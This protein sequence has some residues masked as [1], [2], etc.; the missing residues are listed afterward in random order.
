MCIRDSIKPERFLALGFFI[1]IVAG[2]FVLTLPVSSAD[3]QTVGIRQAMFTATSAVCVTGLTIVDAVSYTHLDVYKRQQHRQQ[4]QQHPGQHPQHHPQKPLP[5]Q[6]RHAR[7]ARGR[8]LGQMC[9]RD[10]Y[11]TEAVAFME[12]KVGGG[13]IF[14]AVVHM[15]EKTP[16]L[17]LCFTPVSYTHLRNFVKEA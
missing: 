7:R 9:I 13:N 14:S 17:H 11:F 8:G 6:R 5:K 3:G 1:L 16:H 15:D 12:K 10:S 4:R 2:G